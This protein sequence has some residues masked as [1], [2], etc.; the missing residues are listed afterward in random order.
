M[1]PIMLDLSK[2]SVALIGSGS[3]FERRRKL[4]LD[5]GATKLT[6]YDL[7][8]TTQIDFNQFNV[9]MI[10]D[11]DEATTKTLHIEAKAAGCIVNVEDEK[12]FCDFYF[13]TFIQRGDLQI[14][15]ST[16]GKSP[17]TA[18]MIRESI[19]TCYPE[20]WE[21]RLEEI[22]AK[23]GEWKNAGASY[24]EVNRKTE[25]YVKS[26]DWLCKGRMSS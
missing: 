24:D 20:Q 10:V 4:L 26:R 18:R 1:L 21:Q 13:Q 19:E 7:Q 15:V 14:S 9:V 25:E 5:A 3:Q 2:L 12:E 23:R 16:N 6:T 11:L 8:H 17:A 22:A